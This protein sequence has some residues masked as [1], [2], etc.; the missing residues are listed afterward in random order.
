MCV[1]LIDSED[2]GWADSLMLIVDTML[3]PI[4]CMQLRWNPALINVTSEQ[5]HRWLL[6]QP[7]H[8]PALGYIEGRTVPADFALSVWQLQLATKSLDDPL[9]E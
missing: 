9:F 8:R 2:V 4:L 7:V 6:A 5:E 1:V 3:G